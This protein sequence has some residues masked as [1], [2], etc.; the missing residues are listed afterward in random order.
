MPLEKV[1]TQQISS[2]RAHSTVPGQ[3]QQTALGLEALGQ[4]ARNQEREN[5]VKRCRL[6]IA[7][8][9]LNEEEAIESIIQ[10]TLAAKAHIIA[11]SP[12]TEVDITVVSDGSTDRTVERASKYRDQIKLIIFEKNRGYGAAI[13][14]A[15]Q[16]SDAEL[17]SFL[18]ADGT[19]D[20][21][22]FA[23]LCEDLV[24]RDLDVILGCRLNANSQMPLIRRIGNVIFATLLTAFARNRVRDTA[25]GMR[26]VRRSKLSHLFPLPDG[27]HF[28]PAMS[29][30]AMLSDA[31]TIGEVDMPYKER[32]GE[33]KLRVIKDGFRFLR[34]ILESAFLY[35]P[36]RPWLWMSLSLF[37]AATLL[38]GTPLFHYLQ[39]QNVEEWMI[40]RFVVAN[41]LGTAGMLS[42]SASYLTRQISKIA[43]SQE[44]ENSQATGLTKFFRSGA[45]WLIP[46]ALG[47]TGFALVAA[48]AL[49][50]IETGHTYVHW[51]RFIAMSFCL[52]TAAILVMTRATD[53]VLSLVSVRSR[54][55]ATQ[56]RE[57]S[58]A[59]KA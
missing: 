10:R 46:V 6:C 35:Q 48:S 23:T 25:S 59:A 36:Q 54:Y 24:E 31:V 47:G 33:S 32:V 5:F 56:T 45:F 17:L 37:L 15:W 55:W 27:L 41:F 43:L 20:P 28:T 21:R 29:A 1:E 2:S 7:I 19:C 50:L 9:A 34:V 4:L 16:E 42:L 49:Q 30:R 3:P 11:N 14:Q 22:F 26:V 13:K 8:P 39:N 57:Q 51:S 12:V 52:T 40:Y 53:F 18:D 44:V 38:M 58:Q